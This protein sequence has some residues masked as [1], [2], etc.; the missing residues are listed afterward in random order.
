VTN[1]LIYVITPLLGVLPHLFAVVAP[2]VQNMFV[3][4]T[5]NKLW[6]SEINAAFKSSL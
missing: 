2:T 5:Y 4:G 6:A 3:C 1:T